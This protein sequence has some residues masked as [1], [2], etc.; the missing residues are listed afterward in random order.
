MVLNAG[1]NLLVMRTM[2]MELFLAQNDVNHY[3]MA[4]LHRVLSCLQDPETVKEMS[5]LSF[6]FRFVT[7]MPFFSQE[8]IINLEAKLGTSYNLYIIRGIYCK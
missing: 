6:T 1:L 5:A 7:I 2:C 8:K 3:I 4:A